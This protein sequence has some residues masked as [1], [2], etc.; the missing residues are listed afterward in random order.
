MHTTQ[1]QQQ[2]QQQQ[3]AR[4]AAKVGAVHLIAVF[5]KGRQTL[6]DSSTQTTYVCKSRELSIIKSGA[7]LHGV[8]LRSPI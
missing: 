8:I 4:L 1:Q 6:S 7:V 3:T 5:G 2:Q